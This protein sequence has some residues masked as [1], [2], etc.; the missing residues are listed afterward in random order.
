[1]ETKLVKTKIEQVEPKLFAATVADEITACITDVLADKPK[2]SLVLAGGSTPAAVYRALSVPPRNEQIDWKR[3]QLFWGDERWVPHTDNQSN[4]KMVQ[5]TLLSKLGTN[6]PEVYGVDTA[7]GSTELGA[8]AY[9]K[10]ILSACGGSSVAEL[11]FDLVLLGMGEDGH[12][13]SIFPGAEIPEGQI[14]FAATNPH[15]HTKRL[16]LTPAALFSARRIIF[17]VN[18]E[19]KAGM[20][21]RIFAKEGDTL[22]LPARHYESAAERV[23]WF[24]D[25]GAAKELK[26]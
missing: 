23:T 24:I 3:V 7:L 9:A 21:K 22:E 19:N 2:C 18:G 16:S 1:M 8:K 13:A 25:T 4:F 10:A 17:I 5:E 14:C 6:R 11:K 20:L 26:L 15:D 12:T